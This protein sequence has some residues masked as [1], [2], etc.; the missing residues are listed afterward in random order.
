MAQEPTAITRHR[1]AKGCVTADI[2]VPIWK[3]PHFTDLKPLT[4][5]FTACI[6]T[7]EITETPELT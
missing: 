6:Y 4:Y 1:R 5:T 2:R 7:S 3:V